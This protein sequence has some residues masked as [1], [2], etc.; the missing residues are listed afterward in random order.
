MPRL[1][2]PLTIRGIT[3]RNRV[4]ISP[5]CQNAAMPDGSLGDWHL[6]HLG[7][8]AMGGAALVFVESTAVAEHARINEFDT[9]L[10]GDHQIAP[11]R[12]VAD[13]VRGRGA[14]FGVQIGHA[15]R[16]AGAAILCDGGAPLSPE[17][18]ATHRDRPFRRLGP[19][20]VAAGEEWT[21][22]EEMSRADIDDVRA[23]FVAAAERAE[24][25]GAD[26]LELH[27]AHG[28]LVASF[29]SPKSNLRTDD[30]G[31]GFAGRT[32]LA[33][34]IATD[35]RAVWPESK[36]LFCR[37]SVV[38]GARHG[39]DIDDSVK[40]AKLLKD[41][42]VDVI[43]CSSGGLFDATKTATAPR[44][45]GFQVH[46]AS[47]IRRDAGIPTQ[48][49]GMI[50]DPLQAEEIL[51][52]GDA[53]LIAIGREA[54]YDPYWASHAA[55]AFGLDPAFSAWSRHNAAYLAKRRPT[56]ERLGLEPGLRERP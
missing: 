13:F 40:L 34:D 23:S 8:F 7:Q 56:M 53:D 39:W 49:V 35:V 21:V 10:W 4:V 31:H 38:D 47:R 55:Q 46:Y 16:K 44:G 5:M 19:S 11:M 22:P 48:A 50:V 3:L 18:L 27:F 43:D 25:A 9:G 41:A 26:V 36:P 51:E 42:G 37:L 12:R 32:R 15:G 24:A 28:Y 14:A 1:F 17:E 20:P 54:L 29:L 33:L 45:L 6:V 2:S 30:Y 52:A